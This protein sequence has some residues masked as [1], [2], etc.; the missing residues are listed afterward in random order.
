MSYLILPFKTKL[1]IFLTLEVA[2]QSVK[3]HPS[4]LCWGVILRSSKILFSSL[5]QFSLKNDS[6]WHELIKIDFRKI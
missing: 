2:L 1:I 5:D 4:M 3:N 6:V